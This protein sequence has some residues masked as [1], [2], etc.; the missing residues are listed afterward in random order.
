MMDFSLG[1]NPPFPM[2]RKPRGNGGRDTAR[3][4]AGGVSGYAAPA[5]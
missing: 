5:I 2:G 1:K 3:L 4:G